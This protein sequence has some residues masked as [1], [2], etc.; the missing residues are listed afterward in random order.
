[1]EKR[2]VLRRRFPFLRTRKSIPPQKTANLFPW[3][4]A[5]LL[6]RLQ[7][8]SAGFAVFVLTVTD[9][10]ADARC[11][12]RAPEAAWLALETALLAPHAASRAPPPGACAQLRPATSMNEQMPN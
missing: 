8:G 2:S 3:P 10:G 9:G 1:M 12:R 6:L 7:P 11:R 5:A 4:F